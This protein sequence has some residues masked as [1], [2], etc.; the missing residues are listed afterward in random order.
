MRER[1]DERFLGG[2]GPEARGRVALGRAICEVG[3]TWFAPAASMIP[4]PLPTIVPL[5]NT[6]R[7]SFFQHADSQESSTRSRSR[8]CVSDF[9]YNANAASFFFRCS[10]WI[11]LLMRRLFFFFSYPCVQLRLR[12]PALRFR[13][14]CHRRRRRR[15]FC[16]CW[17]PCFV[18]N[19]DCGG[20]HLLDSVSKCDCRP[21]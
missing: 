10:V 19:V 5:A 2:S 1:Q 16:C 13:V 17:M 18:A 7:L 8:P 6:G 4:R 15:C 11:W 21:I 14:R 12:G 9:Q 20:P 3:G